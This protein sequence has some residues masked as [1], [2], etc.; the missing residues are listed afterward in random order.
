M[1]WGVICIIE[2]ILKPK[3]LK[4]VRMTHS[5]IWNTSY[6][7]KKSQESNWQ[8]DSWPLKVGNRPNFLVC[9]WFAT[10]HWKVLDEGYKFVFNLISIEGL[11]TKLWGPKVVGVLTLSISGLPFG[12][13]GTKCH[14]DVGLVETHKIYYKG[15][16]DG[17]LKFVPWW[18]LWVWVCPSLPEFARG[19]S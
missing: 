18:I 17:F 15:E 5:D 4:W 16:G 2:K 3:C 19:S 10:Y 6:G 1:D 12:S 13:P 8:F 11:N 7:Q 9:R 14:L